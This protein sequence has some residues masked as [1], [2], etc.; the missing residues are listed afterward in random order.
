[1]ASD[2]VADSA[3]AQCKLLGS[4]GEKLACLR[5]A[6]KTLMTGRVSDALVQRQV[7]SLELAI[8]ATE[9]ALG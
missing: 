5:Q 2:D 1:M 8:V 9:S 7:T 6:L 4:K 3:I